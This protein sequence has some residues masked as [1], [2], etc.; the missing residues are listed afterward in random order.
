MS[1]AT[2]APTTPTP[3]PEAAAPAAP[4]APARPAN[5]DEAL[6]RINATSRAANERARDEQGK[7]TPAPESA[8]A[9]KAPEPTAAQKRLLK[10]K[11]DHEEKDIDFDEWAKEQWEK[12]RAKEVVERDYGFDRRLERTRAE[13]VEA[14]RVA[15]N[16]F[17]NDHNYDLVQDP[18]HPSGWKVVSKQVAMPATS[19]PVDPLAKE[20]AELLAQAEDG[21]AKAVLRITEIRAQR[22]AQQQFKAWEA[23][24]AQRLQTQEQE[25]AYETAKRDCYAQIDGFLS[26]RAKSFEGPDAAKRTARIRDLAFRAAVEAAQ[27]GEHPLPAA[28]A[29]VTEEADGL[30]ARAAFWR[31]SA[32]TPAPKPTAP[33]VLGTT[34]AVGGAQKPK[35]M[36]E[37]YAAVERTLASRNR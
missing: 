2:P 1:E 35:N 6:D 36:D 9:P 14:S 28:Q 31:T 25:R 17:L 32:V 3:A 30:D 23:A 22:I 26:A 27:R 4:S 13:A 21:D 37:A 18:S 16:K 8:S 33:P 29:V 15:W 19:A 5:M 24:Q 10:A 12:G 7:F 20:E 11:F 34:P